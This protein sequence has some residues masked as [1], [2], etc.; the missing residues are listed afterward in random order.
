VIKNLTGND[1]AKAKYYEEDQEFLLGFEETVRHFEAFA[2]VDSC[3]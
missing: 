3:S 1:I 2:W